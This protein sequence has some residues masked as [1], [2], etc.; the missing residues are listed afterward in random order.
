LIVVQMGRH[1][2]KWVEMLLVG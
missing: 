2:M 1:V